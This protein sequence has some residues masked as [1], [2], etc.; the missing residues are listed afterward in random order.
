[1]SVNLFG[2]ISHIHCYE[3]LFSKCGKVCA[4][5][6]KEG[7]IITYICFLLIFAKVINHNLKK[8]RTS[9]VR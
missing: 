3:N 9:S 1:M 4:V 8:L 2:V 6:K 5:L 7:D